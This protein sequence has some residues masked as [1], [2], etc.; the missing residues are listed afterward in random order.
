R[1]DRQGDSLRIGDASLRDHPGQS[2][3]P[4]LQR[5]EVVS[6][7]RDLEV[8]EA[9]PDLPELARHLA[10]VLHGYSAGDG[11]VPFAVDDAERDVRE[12]ADPIGR[13]PPGPGEVLPRLERK[14]APAR[15][16]PQPVVAVPELRRRRPPL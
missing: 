5:R 13:A 11:A 12:V 1:V 2:P 8:L 3:G 16:L 15:L 4:E 14:R 6:D 10:R 7:V 9:G